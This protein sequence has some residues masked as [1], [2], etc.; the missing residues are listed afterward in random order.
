MNRGAV[1]T[2]LTVVACLAGSTPLWAQRYDFK[3]YGQD[4]GLQNLAVQVVLQDREGFLWVGTQNGL[5]R[6]DGSRFKAFTKDDGLPGARIESLHEAADGTLWV[7]TGTGLARINS[8]KFET[9]PLGSAHGVVGREGIASDPQ[10]R[11]YLATDRGLLAGTSKGN[12]VDFTPVDSGEFAGEAVSVYLDRSGRLWFG[13]GLDLCILENGSARATGRE[14]GLPRER[15]DAILENADGTLWVRSGKSLYMLSPGSNRFQF[16]TGVAESGDT[17]PALGLDSLGRLLVPTKSGLARR[18]ARGWETVTV[19]DGLGAGDIS[20]VFRDREGNIWLGLLGSGLARWL[21]YNE[22]QSWSDREGLSRSSVWSMA[23]SKG[24]D[25]T[26]TLWAGTQAG[27]DYAQVREGR[28]VWKHQTIPGID[29]IR[30]IVPGPD[31][32]LWIGDE[33]GVLRLDSRTGR[34]QR[35]G[36][37]EGLPGRVQHLMADHD[38]RVWASTRQ[39]LY[40]T[41][42]AVR[43]STP[44]RFAQALPPG[45]DSSER[46]VMTAE[47]RI[48]AVWAAGDFGLA[49]FSGGQ[50]VRYTVADGLKNSMVAQV[51]AD[52]DGSVWIGYRDAFGITHMSFDAGGRPKVEYFTTA[53]ALRSDKSIFLGFDRRGWLW[54]GT[55]HGADVFDRTRWRHFGR[56]DGLIW[57][58]CNTNAFLAADDGAVWIGTSRGLSRFEPQPVPPPSIPPQVIF[59]SVTLSGNPLDPDGEMEVPGDRGPLQVR[60]TA[61]TF[62]NESGLAFRYRLGGNGSSWQETTGRELS[63]PALPAPLFTLEVEAQNGQGVWSAPAR[64]SFQVETPWWL[65]TWRT[66]V[67][68]LSLAGL[69]RLFWRRRMRRL[70]AER[71]AL[72]EAVEERTHELAEAKARAEEEKA[73]VDQQKREIERLLDEAQEVSRHKSE[74]LANMSHEIR[75]PMNGVIGMTSLVLATELT[76]EQREYLDTARLSADSL[77]T[78]LNDILDFSKI[79]AGRLDLNLIDFSLRDCLE[80]IGRMLSLQIASRKLEYS[81]SVADDVPDRLVGD[82]DRLRQILV[83]LLGNAVKFTER[84]GISISVGRDPAADDVTLL[85]AVHDSGIGIPADKQ[86]LIFD[87]FRQA[88]G[89]TTRKYG[90]TGLGLAICSRLVELMGGSIWVESELGRGSTFHFSARLGV[91]TETPGE[92]DEKARRLAMAVTTFNPEPLTALR[93]LLAEDNPVNQRLATKLLEKRGHRVTVAATGSGAVQRAQDETF[94]VVLMDVQMP[95]MD[96]L[97]ATALIREWEKSRGR[98]TPIIALTAHSMK[99]DRERCLSAGMD[100]YVTK[101]FDAAQLIAVVEATARPR[102]QTPA[103]VEG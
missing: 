39:G 84:G 100:N 99:G 67:V 76:D 36:A 88:D 4:E 35:L 15:W 57:D 60:F 87:A 81:L 92:I 70:V 46:F 102:V 55:D 5:F 66:G 20:A 21:G 94:D 18:A 41:T 37:A 30:T 44:V 42:Q 82:P 34:V 8:G 63:F 51:A 28:L 14:M 26:G 10:G 58:D 77:L 95:D 73:V 71:R 2:L 97:E 31:G 19:D 6:Y 7:G 9:V 38:G 13:C 65:S 52:Q 45:S 74:F 90:G 32:A 85:F 56:S 72:E 96:G 98:R 27:L 89:S 40:R 25:A 54:V 78:V 49:R 29:T 93:I 75:T 33:A 16:Q 62:A 53:N 43:T 1:T 83:N 48:G 11:L 23:W 79:E 64:L 12:R 80:Q 68:V 59:T 24:S 69:A 101:P 61:L 22:W 47:D 3:F 17:Y 50:W 103:A 86:D 91:A